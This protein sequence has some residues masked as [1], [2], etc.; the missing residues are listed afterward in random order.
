VALVAA[1]NMALLVVGA[2]ITAVGVVLLVVALT[3]AL[4]RQ[5]LLWRM[6]RWVAWYWENAHAL[7]TDGMG[8][9]AARF[10][11]QA[12]HLDRHIRAAMSGDDIP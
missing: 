10:R 4:R 11:A 9:T 12:D 2:V 3:L 8:E 1:V 5:V 7:D 6:Q